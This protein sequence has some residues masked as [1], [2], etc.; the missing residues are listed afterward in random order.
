MDTIKTQ[1]VL[2]GFLSDMELGQPQQ[3]KNMT[4]IPLVLRADRSPKYLTLRETLEKSVL[5]VTEVIQSGSVPD[6]K[7]INAGDSAVLLIDGEELIGAKA[8]GS[9]WSYR[10][11]SLQSLDCY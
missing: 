3:F 10:F 9:E 5:T 7:V 6:L 8:A 4:V 11:R 1:G 2:A